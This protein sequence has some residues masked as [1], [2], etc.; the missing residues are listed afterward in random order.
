MLRI[1]RTFLFIY[2]LLVGLAFLL[3]YVMI[4]P[5]LFNQVW[6]YWAVLALMILVLVLLNY[7]TFCHPTPLEIV[8][9][10]VNLIMRHPINQVEDEEYNE[11]N[12]LYLSERFIESSNYQFFY[13]EDCCAK[14]NQFH[15]MKIKLAIGEES[16]NKTSI[17]IKTMDQQYI[18]F[19]MIK[20]TDY[21]MFAFLYEWEVDGIEYTDQSTFE[22]MVRGY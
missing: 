1:N 17:I 21:S 14:T 12:K 11:K 18:R 6:C 7:L 22:R 19:N 3:R 4:G 15:R 16:F 13:Y 5:V 10:H 2:N 8:A 9:Y 20:E